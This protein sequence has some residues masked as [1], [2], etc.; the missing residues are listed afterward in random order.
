MH[1]LIRYHL[2]VQKPMLGQ[3]ERAKV[4]K[5]ASLRWVRALALEVQTDGL[6]SINLHGRAARD[7]ENSALKE[8]VL[9]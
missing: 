8:L 6:H 7:E 1:F 5:R 3:S 4:G 9:R 2:Q